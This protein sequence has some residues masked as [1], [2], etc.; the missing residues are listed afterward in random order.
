M[1]KVVYDKLEIGPRQRDY[2]GEKFG[3]WTVLGF[4]G[5]KDHNH[6]C[7]AYYWRCE[8][9]C[10]K[11][12]HIQSGALTSG[13]ST[14]CMVCARREPP[15]EGHKKPGRKKIVV[16]FIRGLLNREIT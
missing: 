4:A 11:E 1:T 15:K 7:Y 5:R 6:K 8:C 3:R 12:E 9:E 10:G 14:Q 16:S 13:R 2:T